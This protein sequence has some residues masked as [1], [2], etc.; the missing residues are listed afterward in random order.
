MSKSDDVSPDAGSELLLPEATIELLALMRQGDQ[1]ALDRLFRR[2]LPPLRRW[3]HGRL[4]VGARGM[5]DTTDVVQDAVLAAIRHLDSFE[6]R[7]QGAL[8]AYL[9]Q[10]VLNRIRDLYRQ[11][12]RRPQDTELRSDLADV[13]PSPLEQ[14]IGSENVERYERALERLAEDDREAVI[15]RIEMQ[16]SYAELAIVLNKST[17]D[18]ARMCVTRAVRRLLDEMRRV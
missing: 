9:R 8:Q 18:A 2:C 12:H 13:V 5:N 6:A 3:A 4:P 11:A 17:P 15:G 10:A 1:D 7:H 16:Y 14:A